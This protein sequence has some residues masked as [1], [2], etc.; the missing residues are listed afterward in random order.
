MATKTS[1]LIL[2]LRIAKETQKLFRI[3]SYVT[4]AVVNIAGVV[5]TFL[6]AFQCNP[7]NAAYT[8]NTPGTCISIVTLYLCSAPVNIITD[9]AILVLPIPVLTG[10]RLPRRQKTILVLTFALG[11]FVTIVNVIRIYYLQRA[12]HDRSIVNTS[13]GSGSDFSWN[14]STALMWSVIEVNVGIICAC[15]PTLRPL[16]TQILPSIIMDR[17]STGTEKTARASVGFNQVAPDFN[18]EPAHQLPSNTDPVPGIQCLPIT[19]LRGNQGNEMGMIDFLPTPGMEGA[20]IGRTHTAH[21][22]RTDTSVYFGFIEMSRPKSM[23]KTK[24]RE[25]FTYC[26]TVTILFFIWGFSNGLTSTL[27]TEIAKI[28]NESTSQTLGLTSA[29]WGAYFFL[30]P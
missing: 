21:T 15:I 7:P 30:A 16:I 17:P 27:N 14:A 22:Q 11:I 6:N 2:Y 3:A 10:I 18:A 13:L 9:L 5:L 28:A 8:S 25:A 26:T 23:L 19:Q 20:E 29:Y 1:I 24:G 12:N 4:L